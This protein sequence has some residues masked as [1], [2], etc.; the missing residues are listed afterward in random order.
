MYRATTM[1]ESSA[2][3]TPSLRIF[4]RSA[5]LSFMLTFSLLAALV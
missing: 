4:V 2:S 1:R 5:T 3:M